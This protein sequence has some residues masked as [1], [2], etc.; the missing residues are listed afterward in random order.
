MDT[1]K[2][3]SSIHLIVAKLKKRQELTF[4]GWVV[5]ASVLEV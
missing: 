1:V 4:F 2:L 5:K 3:L